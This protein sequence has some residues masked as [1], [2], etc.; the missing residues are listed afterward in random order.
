MESSF[1]TKLL[2]PLASAEALLL[3][4]VV[5]P[6]LMAMMLMIWARIVTLLDDDLV[7]LSGHRQAWNGSQM[8]VGILGYGLWLLIPQFWLGMSVCLLLTG[9]TI[10]C[11]VHHRNHQVPASARWTPKS[12][13]SQSWG[14][15]QRVWAKHGT[16]LTVARSNGQVLETPTRK[17][18]YAK[19]HE[20]LEQLLGYA[21]S[22]RTER[23][24]IRASNPN[25]MVILQIDGVGYRQPRLDPS[26]AAILIDYLKHCA[27]LEVCERRLKLYGDLK[28]ITGEGQRHNLAITTYGSL[29][30]LEMI[31]D[32]DRESRP[33]FD[34]NQLGL[35]PDQEEHLASTLSQNN[36][37]V[38]IATPPGHGQTTMLYGMLHSHHPNK[39]KIVTVQETGE[40]DLP[41]IQRHQMQP[42][43]EVS[44]W[45]QQIRTVVDQ[46]PQV[47]MVELLVHPQVTD[48]LV[49]VAH[50]LR[51]YAGLRDGD[52]F[53]A[54]TSWIRSVGKADTAADKLGAIMAGRVLRRLCMT[55]RQ[56]YTP[57]TDTLKKLNLS[58]DRIGRL[59]KQGGRVQGKRHQFERCP[60]CLGLGYN[61][62]VGVYEVMVLDDQCRQLITNQ[63]TEQL[64]IHLRQQKMILLQEAALARVID[65]TTTI[66][67]LTRVL[68][69]H[70]DRSATETSS[71]VSNVKS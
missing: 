33:K 3:M 8:T 40:F 1:N 36:R 10:G 11:Y 35:L 25:P 7:Y 53:D 13:F 50:D 52:T 55:C 19:T 12:L 46:K 32:I 49:E 2:P 15:A 18:P 29:R 66:S 51:V 60:D 37:I 14:Q 34:L 31:V 56:P 42:G 22:F 62:R 54:L 45:I 65:G 5:K 28:V 71:R 24:L 27:G 9:S 16:A 17:K 44:Q 61:G 59:Y 41:G 67:E 70:T 6:V 21:L 57:H 26:A 30:G 63:Q 58:P 48:T 23:I 4:S 69:Q 38:L 20:T 47:L 68:G 39:Q 64:R 43:A